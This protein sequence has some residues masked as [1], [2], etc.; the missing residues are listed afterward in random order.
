MLFVSTLVSHADTTTDN[1]LNNNSFT[2]DTSGWELSD[3]NQNKVKR[4]PATYSGSASKS[5]RFRYQ[6]GSIS[7]DVDIS[8]VAENHIVKEVNMTFN[9][10]GCG[11]SGNQWCNA[12]AHDTVVNAVTLSST[13]VTEVITNTKELPY[14]DGW[15]SYSFTEE[16]DE[17]F[18]TNDLE[19]NLTITGNDTGNS[20]NWYG[21]II[22]NIS[23]TFTIEEYVAPVVIEPIVEP[24]V[25]EPI[26][27]IEETL[28]EGL[29]LDTEI[30]NDVIL[31]PISIDIP[32]LPELPDLPEVT[33]IPS[34]IPE[35]SMNIE[36]P[37]ISVDIPEIPVEVPEIE[38]VEEIQEIEV[39]SE[40]VVEEI[41]EVELET[42]EELKD[43]NM[44]DDIKE[45]STND[46]PEEMAEQKTETETET[47]E[48]SELS[49]SSE[50]EV[51]SDESK[52]VKKSK[53]KDS[54]TKKKDGVKKQTAKNTPSK[55]TKTNKPKAVAKVKKPATNADNLGQIDI[56]TMVYLQVIPQTITI[57]ETISLTQENIYEQ[58]VGTLA[59]SATYDSLIGSA[60]RRWVRMVD[61][62][63]KHTF[64]SYG[65]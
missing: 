30:V 48:N 22:D 53:S 28:I 12:G 15:S 6:G 52:V 46:E 10:I 65:R 56:T 42:P 4:D 14:E 37:E 18:N 40:P 33:E 59:S 63:P 19:V 24:L 13:E 61:V 5:V 35:V 47:N 8:G 50:A 25:V 58:D 45:G 9:G 27:V 1:L 62:R 43:S 7:Q 16:V 57:Q 39:V 11:N 60:S 31:Q 26:V 17:S 34:E 38:V 54:K 3:N 23:L 51:K 32:E 20:S 64:S 29:S 21:P 55:T 41:A 49:D 44:E 2:T 36:M